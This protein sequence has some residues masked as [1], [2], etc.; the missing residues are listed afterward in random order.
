MLRLG[1]EVGLTGQSC[2][3]NWR[4]WWVSR[5]GEDILPWQA[6]DVASGFSNPCTSSK[7]PISSPPHGLQ[8]DYDRDG[9][10]GGAAEDDHWRMT[11]MLFGSTDSAEGEQFKWAFPSLKWPGDVTV[12]Q[13]QGTQVFLMP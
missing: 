13:E 6:F 12:S 10:D 8:R 2:E 1:A 7:I 9:F 3:V 4:L 5:S 11:H